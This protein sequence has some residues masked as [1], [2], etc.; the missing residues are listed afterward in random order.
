[1]E[2]GLKIFALAAFVLFVA[3]ST[4]IDGTVKIGYINSAAII[5]DLPDAKMADADLKVLQEQLQKRAQK[6][7]ANFETAYKAAAEKEQAGQLS[8]AQLAEE[9]D[10]LNT[11]RETI[12]ENDQTMRKQL[13]DKQLELMGPIMEKV[14]NAINA[15]GKEGGYQVVFDVSVPG[16]DGRSFVVYA[17]EAQDISEAVKAKL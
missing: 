3:A 8:P 16:G 11:Q 15:V 13:G 12:A 17:D 9:Q 1:M 7:V 2:K 6:M 10:K 4:A 5:A 14:G